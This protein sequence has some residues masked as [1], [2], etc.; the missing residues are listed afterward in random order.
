MGD[1]IKRFFSEQGFEYAIYVVLLILITNSV[2]I[3]Y[4]RSILQKNEELKA[5]VI[6]LNYRNVEFN[7][8]V[9][10]ADMAIRGYILVPEKSMFELAMPTTESYEGNNSV[11]IRIMEKF[12][13]D[14]SQLQKPL[15]VYEEYMQLILRMA[16]LVESGNTQEAI[17]ILKS[18]PGFAAWQG[19]SPLQQELT[20]MVNELEVKAEEEHAMIIRNTMLSQILLL[21]VVI[22]F[23]IVVARKMKMSQQ[24]RQ[25]L[26]SDLVK[27]RQKYLFNQ[28][29]DN[30]TIERSNILN[31]E[32]TINDI[33]FNLQKAKNF[34][35]KIAEGNYGVEW[36]GLNDQN[37]EKNEENLV[38][39]L[40]KMRDQMEKM[41]KADEIRLWQTEG[42]TKFSD[43]IR[44]NQNNLSELSDRIVSGLVNYLNAKQGGIF[45]LNE[46][47]DG[48]KFLELKGCYAYDRRKYLNKKIKVG[49]GLVGQCFLERQHIYLK[50]V[51]ENY[52]QISSGLGE[53]KPSSLV[54]TPLKFENQV[55]G[56][57]E[58]ASLYEFKDHEIE[59][60][61]QLGETIASA[62]LTTKN[63]QNTKELLEKSQQQAEEMR[64]Q[65]EEMRQNMEELEATQEEMTRKER[66]ISKLLEEAKMRENEIKGKMNEVEQV[67]NNLEIENA[68]FSSLMNLLPDRVTI[69]DK[70]GIYLRVNKTKANSLKL[71]GVN[72]YIGKS[73]RDIFGEKHF[74]TSYKLEKELMDNDQEFFNKEEKVKMPDGRMMWANTTWTIFKSKIGE[75]LGTIVYTKDV[76]NEKTCLEDL[77]SVKLENSNLKG[78]IDQLKKS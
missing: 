50:N 63:N 14:V 17:E 45:I 13:Y 5:D 43:I 44:N 60:L 19:Y 25:K 75:V 6:E 18:D 31:E 65:E 12:G 20:N 33:V 67:K 46:A 39:E 29:E 76:T 21:I 55:I 35:G 58:L 30:V 47:D 59:F 66:E 37:L 69:K 74:E 78:E 28:A 49:D 72:E 34:I 64:A 23:L 15:Q 3:L 41:K 4:Y 26:F 48:D 40:I 70:N 57:I 8:I 51:P 56:V 61:D 32:K 7:A 38:G 24:N 42:V 68:M 73:D 27:S 22:P 53:T 54:L 1:K 16:K 77:E 52:M 71:A 10:R 2:L 62:I 11:I 9:N 36:E